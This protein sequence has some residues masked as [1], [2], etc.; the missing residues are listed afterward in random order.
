M[1]VVPF[2]ALAGA[3]LVID[4][5]Y[6]GGAQKHAGDDPISKLLA[7]VGNQGGFRKCGSTENER[8]V[9]LYTS[10]AETDW[11]DSLD[12]ATGQFTYYGDNRRPGHEL[13]DTKKGGNRLLQRVFSCLHRVPAARSSVPP[14]FVFRSAPTPASA[15]S[16][17]FLGLAVP[18]FPGISGTEDLVAVWKSTEGK[19]FQNYRSVFTVLS[20]GTVS[21]TWLDSLGSESPNNEAA[22]SEW[23]A[24]IE[25]GKYSPLA[26][27]PIRVT[28]TVQQQLPDTPGKWALLTRIRERY[29]EDAHGFERFA[30]RIFQLMDARVVVD[31]VTRAVVDGGKDAFGRYRLGL[32]SDPVFAEFALEAKCYN[33]PVNGQA[34]TTVGVDDVARLISRIKHRQFGVLV[35]TSVVSRQVYEEVREDGHPILFLSARDVAEILIDSGYHQPS[36]L[37]G[38]FD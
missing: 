1:Q 32:T 15:R 18:G 38:L 12:S 28:R 26:A 13:H 34:G 16:V 35:T 3:D 19:R 4:R 10:G 27:P 30:A 6:E 29:A 17:Q 21:R 8:Y 7:G 22:P 33:P 14:F 37:E 23:R 9:V 5:I 31:G 25:S 36:A 24:W 20:S 2:S 11:P